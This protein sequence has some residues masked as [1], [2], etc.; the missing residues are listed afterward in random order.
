M[1]TRKPKASTAH[2]HLQVLRGHTQSGE[3]VYFV[4]SRTMTAQNGWPT[5][6]RMQFDQD[7]Q[8]WMCPCPAH[9]HCAHINAVNAYIQFHRPMGATVQPVAKAERIA[10]RD[11]P[12]M[13]YSGGPAAF[14]SRFAR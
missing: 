2:D 3:H 11:M 14:M 9:R 12:V 8:I 7:R 10:P 6:H 5:Y 1:T 4:Q 13:P